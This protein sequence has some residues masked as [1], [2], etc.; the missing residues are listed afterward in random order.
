MNRH[1]FRRGVFFVGTMPSKVSK[2]DEA[3]LRVVATMFGGGFV[4]IRLHGTSRNS[5][6]F[7]VNGVRQTSWDSDEVTL[8]S[9]PGSVEKATFTVDV[10]ASA[11]TTCRSRGEADIDAT[12]IGRGPSNR[13]KLM[14]LTTAVLP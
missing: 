12:M 1:N 2:G 14:T 11:V 13:G 9:P 7:R 8:D 10:R 3:V 4:K 5:L 6:E